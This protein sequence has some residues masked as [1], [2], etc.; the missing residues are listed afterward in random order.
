MGIFC[1]KILSLSS[2][3]ALNDKGVI[4]GCICILQDLP[5]ETRT[6]QQI[7]EDSHE[8]KED[9]QAQALLAQGLRQ[10]IRLPTLTLHSK[11][12]NAMS[13]AE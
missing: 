2:K 5:C 10:S 7:M 1:L 13:N 11:W 4:A 6:L 3:R 8:Q 9:K 12:C